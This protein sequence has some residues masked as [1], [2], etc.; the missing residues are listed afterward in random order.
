MD[1]KADAADF[2]G[3]QARADGAAKDVAK[4]KP[5]VALW[6]QHKPLL[7][8]LDV[9]QVRELAGRV[10]EAHTSLFGLAGKLAQKVSAEDLGTA[11]GSLQAQ[12]AE[13]EERHAGGADEFAKLLEPKADRAE[14]ARA[15][16]A[17]ASKGEKDG[18]PVLAFYTDKPKFHCLSCNRPLPKIPNSTDAE[19]PPSRGAPEVLP[20]PSHGQGGGSH[21]AGHDRVLVP[22]Y[23][24]P[25]AKVRPP[26]RQRAL[27]PSEQHKYSL[28][29]A[30][31]PPPGLHGGGGGPGGGSNA[32]PA[33]GS[34]LPVEQGA[35]ISRYQRNI[36]NK[37][38][39]LQLPAGGGMKP[40]NT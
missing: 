26:P 35:P 27:P 18:D 12:F 10:D 5:E 25:L 9:D 16:R 2:L 7:V 4:L 28:D 32:M 20:P 19:R 33:A 8:G 13:L 6:T 30:Q 36:P 1:T 15:V 37:P 29:L 22:N 23:D 31:P 39:R 3:L 21:G 24:A 38:S 17:L 14:L 40:T 34:P 11:L